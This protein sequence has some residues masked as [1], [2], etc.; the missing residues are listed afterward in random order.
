[1]SPG[2]QLTGPEI[3]LPVEMMLQF[4][5]YLDRSDDSDVKAL[6]ACSKVS[7]KWNAVVLPLLFSELDITFMYQDNES[8]GDKFARDIHGGI[9]YRH[10]ALVFTSLQHTSRIL[11]HVQKLHLR[12]KLVQ[13][14]TAAVERN[15]VDSEILGN[16]IR[17]FPCLTHLQ[18]T[19]VRLRNRPEIMSGTRLQDL[20]EVLLE[21][22]W[23]H[24]GY[25]LS[26]GAQF[27][28]RLWMLNLF[29]S[30]KHLDLNYIDER[31]QLTAEEHHDILTVLSQSD[32]SVEAVTFSDTTSA[33]LFLIAFQSSPLVLGNLKSL[34]FKQSCDPPFFKE[35]A[36]L[37]RNLPDGLAHLACDLNALGEHGQ[38]CF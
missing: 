37:Y 21:L 38:Q 34:D 4:F 19:N 20:E 28:D 22:P 6:I 16:V 26:T 14:S 27:V 1:M 18:L 12:Q 15:F 36:N 33:H 10:L 35:L 25:Y 31:P 5:S 29:G 7:R 17:L 3:D 13:H 11:P 30:V 32:F 24:S 23:G 8:Q 9:S 2:L